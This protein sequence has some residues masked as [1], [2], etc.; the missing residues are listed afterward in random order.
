[1]GIQGLLPQL[2]PIQN[3]VTLRRYEGQILGIDGYAWLH[4]AAYSCA[5]EL[6]L[7]KP[8]EKYL[9]FFIKKISMLRNFKIEPYIVFDGGS[10][11]V[12][13][14]TELKRKQK[15]E[16]NKAIAERL[17]NSGDKAHAMEYFQK[18]VDITPEMA[19][20][21]IDYCKI[22]RIRYIV[23]PF[24]AD[25]QM[26][27]LEKNGLIDGIISEDS[28]LLIFGCRKLITKLN[29]FGECIEICSDDF[30]QLKDKFP[31]HNMSLEGMRTMVALSGCDYTDGLPKIGLVRAIK[32]VQRFNKMEKIINHIKLEGKVTVPPTFYEE[33]E[34]ANYSFQF[35]RVY[36]PQRRKIVTMNDIPE[37]YL[38]IPSIA[39]KIAKAI[40]QPIHLISRE[41]F[42]G[43]NSEDIDHELHEK[44]ALGELNSYIFNKP[45]ISR[46]LTLQLTTTKSEIIQRNNKSMINRPIVNKGRTKT[47]E[48][49][50]G[51]RRAKK[52]NKP[53]RSNTTIGTMSTTLLDGVIHST[54]QNP[55]YQE[56][57]H[58]STADNIKASLHR[59]ENKTNRVITNRLL[60]VRAKRTSSI[61]TSI[62]TG[63]LTET[64]S[65]SKFFKKTQETKECSTLLTKIPQ[66]FRQPSTVRDSELETE[67]PESM[68]P[69]EVSTLPV[70][71]SSTSSSTSS[72][73]QRT[74]NSNVSTTTYEDESPSDISELS[75]NE[76]LSSDGPTIEQGKD[77]TMD[78][79]NHDKSKPRKLIGS[80]N[81][82]ESFKY[83]SGNEE[84]PRSPFKE[85]NPNQKMDV[86]S[87]PIE[88]MKRSLK[89]LNR[90]GKNSIVCS[91]KRSGS[92]DITDSDE[93]KER[94][95]SNSSSSRRITITVSRSN[96]QVADDTEGKDLITPTT[97]KIIKPRRKIIKPVQKSISA[98]AGFA[99]KGP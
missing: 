18:C 48:S 45:L 38:T 84:N 51:I 53:I 33:Y 99:Y 58:F 96:S 4:R 34:L 83:R 60:T 31:L 8:T 93:A 1:M 13:K 20:C 86:S 12:K 74:T 55:M 27:Y 78:K 66:H 87:N 35:Q 89:D 94:G 90:K 41:R 9:Q 5:Q 46:E 32:L 75:E 97:K 50:F 57:R 64:S 62:Q 49:F 71:A 7:G 52:E 21:I 88:D 61:T 37:K 98:L 65:T 3:P 82:L 59:Q 92:S 79:M 44:I 72:S 29:D 95:I 25:S 16:E 19:K 70:S 69:T 80:K 54:T 76:P 17:W 47:I 85:Y 23:A 26:V 39:D 10:I 30:K 11:S 73:S 81:F 77:V 2:K 56:R 68:V 15:R 6:V 67:V 24:E 40:G 43:I 91:V 14:D 22:N 36:C 63:D 42:C 28:D